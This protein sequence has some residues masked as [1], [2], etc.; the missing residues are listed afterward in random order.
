MS[1]FKNAVRSALVVAL[2]AIATIGGHPVT[3]EAA[4]TSPMK[5]IYKTTTATKAT[6]DYDPATSIPSRLLDATWDNDVTPQDAPWV[7]LVHGGSWAPWNN[8]GRQLMG[9]AEAAF[10]AAGF[11]VFSVDYRDFS[12]AKWPAQS[13]DVAQSLIWIKRNAAQFGIDP[14]RGGMYG[15]SA[16]A[17]IAAFMAVADEGALRTNAFI[18][19]S[20]AYD[21]TLLWQIAQEPDA[22][23]LQKSA[24]INAERLIGVSPTV[25]WQAWQNA[26]VTERLTPGDAPMYLVHAMDDP[27]VPR[28]STHRVAY[29]ADSPVTT[30]YPATG[31]HGQAILW[32]N[33]TYKAE[34]I[35]FMKRETAL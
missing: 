1:K 9:T 16:G 2:A 31:G 5:T 12:Q 4:Y 30:R 35:A 29:Y 11:V 22:T 25:N 32:N 14:R 34:A 23:D 33:P 8:P 7:V 3:V 26:R 17:H 24:G 15:F 19:V 10:R 20:G 18:G 13:L 6:F 28:E 27:A 21:P